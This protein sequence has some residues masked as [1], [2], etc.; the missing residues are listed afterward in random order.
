[1]NKKQRLFLTEL[2]RLLTKY[3]IDE[4]LQLNGVIYFKCKGSDL[5]FVSYKRDKGSV[6]RKVATTEEA[7]LVQNSDPERDS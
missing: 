3:N 5:S 4:V 6:Y 7:Y 2:D 1:M